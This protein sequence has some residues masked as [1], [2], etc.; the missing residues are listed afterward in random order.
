V[1]FTH[2]TPAK[3][4]QAFE[5]LGKTGATKFVV[6]IRNT[7]R[8]DIDDG[9]AS[10]RL[11]VPSG[12]LTVK[13]SKDQREVVS[14]ATSDG[15]LREPVAL[16]VSQGTSGAAEVFAAALEGNSRAE[17]VGEHTIGRAARQRLVKLP[18][19]SGLLLS[20]V[21]YLT[22][23]N[24]AIHERGLAPDVEVDEPEVDFG[25]EPPAGDATLDKAIE[26]LT[27]GKPIEVKKAA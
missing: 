22:P 17:L 4:K 7:A 27:S 3:L 19:G 24:N 14:A 20:N 16:L 25:A 23:K 8:G 21:R 10:A 13:Q 11:F 6:D 26:V 18:D 2:D 5:A 1:D 15:P 12:T 9:I